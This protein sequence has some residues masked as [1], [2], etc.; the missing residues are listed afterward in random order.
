MPLGLVFIQH[1]FDLQIQ[2]AV[3]VRQPFGDIFVH[4]GFTDAEFT[5]GIPHGGS[6][7]DYVNRQIA[8]ALFQIPFDAYHSPK[9]DISKASI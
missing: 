4:R 7:F 9:D 3:K 8:G 2:A 1:F 6:V 5:G